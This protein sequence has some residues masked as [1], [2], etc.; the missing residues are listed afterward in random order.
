VEDF[1]SEPLL[2]YLFV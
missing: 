1:F 2:C